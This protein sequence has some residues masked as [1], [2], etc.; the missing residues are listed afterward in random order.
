KMFTLAG[1]ADPQGR[2]QRVYALEDRIARAHRTREANRDVEKRYNLWSRADFDRLAPGLDWAAFLGEA[3]IG[4]QTTFLIGQPE[5]VT[6]A[7][8]AARDA[9]LAD[10]RDYLAYRVMRNF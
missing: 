4:G 10:W 2:A 1:R 8:A 5:A 9:P 7:A 6:G 3:R